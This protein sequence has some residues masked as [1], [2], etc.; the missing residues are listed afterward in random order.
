MLTPFCLALLL[1]FAA[2]QRV[3]SA[4]RGAWRGEAR[5]G[6]VIYKEAA[7]M[8]RKQKVIQIYP[9]AVFHQTADQRQGVGTK[10]PVS[11]MR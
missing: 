9:P 10:L 6:D 8:K 4:A 1:F 11:G 5:R 3:P 2:C 7:S